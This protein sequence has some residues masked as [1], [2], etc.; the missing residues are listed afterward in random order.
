MNHKVLF[1][2][3]IIQLFA[4]IFGEVTLTIS[5]SE[6]HE[7]QTGKFTPL[8]VT[9]KC[10]DTKVKTTA[11][12]MIF[13]VDVS[14]SMAGDRLTLV[15][16][17]LTYMIKMMNE[18]D[19]VALIKFENNAKLVAG[20]TP[21][22]QANK[23]NFIS[24][25]S[26]FSASGGT[27]IYNGLRMAL[28]QITNNYSTGDRVC[29]IVLLSDG[30]DLYNPTT[31][32]NMFYD[33]TVS[34]GKTKYVFTVH[35]LGYGP[36]HDADLMS[37]ISKVRDGGYAYI[38]DLIT[39]NSVFLQIYGSLST[40]VGS[41]VILKIQSNFKIEK[42]IGMENMYQASLTKAA[43][44]TFTVNLQQMEAGQSY[45]YVALVDISPDTKKDTEVLNATLAAF[46]KTAVY[47]WSDETNPDAYEEY[48]KTIVITIISTG[49][50][51]GALKIVIIND[52]IIW[53]DTSYKGIMDWMY[54]F[55]ELLKEF[56]QNDPSSKASILSKVREL[57]TQKAGTHFTTP[58][59]FTNEKIEESYD[60]DKSGNTTQTL[61]GKGATTTI[62]TDA[63]NNYH[64]FYL[65]SGVGEINDM[66][67]SEQKSAII[68]FNNSPETIKIKS[69]SDN[70]SYYYFASKQTRIQNKIN[71]N[72]G[73][74]FMFRRDLPFDFYTRID[75]NYDIVFNIQFLKLEHGS[76]TAEPNHVFEIKAYILQLNQ[77]AN[78]GSYLTTPM[79]VE[80]FYDQGLR[81]GKISI[82]KEDI[83]KHYVQN[84]ENYLYIVVTKKSPDCNVVYTNVEGQFSFVKVNYISR[85]VPESFYVFN[86][87]N[88]GQKIPHIYALKMEQADGK[89]VRVE[90]ASSGNELD[91]KILRHNTY[92]VS[93]DNLYSDYEKF[94]IKRFNHMGKT[95]ID[96]TQINADKSKHEDLIISI[97]SNNINHVAG[98]QNNKLS[99]TLRFTT[100]S[101]YG[102]YYFNDVNEKN[103]LVTVVR[104]AADAEKISVNFLPIQYKKDDGAYTFEKTRFGVKVYEII[105]TRQ[106][107]YDSIALFEDNLPKMYQEKESTDQNALYFDFKVNTSTNYFLA[108]YTVSS[109]TNEILAY[110]TKKIY[111]VPNNIII[112][113]YN[114]FE[115][116]YNKNIDFYVTVDSSV[117]KNNL[118][119]DVS[120]FENG[121][122][123]S[124]QAVVD[125]TV[126]QST[127]SSSNIILIPRNSC[128]GKKVNIKITLVNNVQAEYYVIVK[129]TDQ[130]YEIEIDEK[131]RLTKTIEKILHEDSEYP[132]AITLENGNVLALS[133]I[134]GVQQM[135]I[136]KL[137]DNAQSIYHNQTIT[138]GYNPD[139][140]LVQPAN[141]NYYVL[142]GH[143][144][145]DLPLRE[146]KEYILTFKDKNNVINSLFRK[147]ALY[148]KTS[149]L[150]LRN[151][152]ILLVGLNYLSGFGAET[153]VDV[154]LFNPKT[155]EILS[156]GQ[157]FIAYSKY[158]SCYEQ[159]DNEVYC[160][161]A[162]FESLFVSK[163]KIRHYTVS[164][165]ALT[166]KGEQSIKTFYTVFNFLKAI[167]YNDEE[168][169]IL[170]QAGNAKD[171]PDVR[172]KG[173]DLYFIQFTTKVDSSSNDI[174]NITRYTYL[175]DDCLYEGQK[176]DAE[177]YNADVAVLSSN[178]IYAICETSQNK[179]KG[180]V[181]YP[182]SDTVHEFYLNNFYAKNV[183]S[184][185]FAKF[186][187]SMGLFYTH[188]YNN[189][190]KFVTYQIMNYPDCHNYQKSPILIPKGFVKEIDF[191]G[192]VFLANPYPPDRKED[193]KVRF[194]SYTNITFTNN[195]N[196][197]NIIPDI[198]YPAALFLKI[199]PRD[200]Y[201]NY[202]IEYTATRK[203][204][205]DG[206]ILGGTCKIEIETPECLE[207]CESCS[208][209]GTNEHNYCLGCKKNGPFYKIND[210]SAKNEG[211]GQPHNCGRCNIS[212]A[213][214]WGAFLDYPDITTNCIKCDYENGFFH[215]EDDERTCISNDTK[216]YW[217]DV[218]GAA[219]YLDS[220]PGP[221]NK[222]SWRWRKCH[223]NCEE[224]LEKGDDIDNKCTF[225]KKDYYFFCN[226]KVGHGIPGSCHTGCKNNGFFVK[227][228]ED[229]EKCCP[230]INHCKECQNSKICDKCYPPY[231]RTD[232]GRLCNETCGYCLAEDRNKW[233]CVNCKEDFDPPRYNLN[234]TCVSEIPFIESL[235]RYHHIVDDTCN[236]L[237]GCK[238][239]CH[240][241]DPWYTDN[242]TM[243]NA[244]Y[245]KEDFY[246]ITPQPKTF[247]CFNKT[248]C[249]GVTKY[250]H[251]LFLRVGGVPILENDINVCLNCKLRNDSY[252]LPEDDF[253]CGEKINRTFNDI[254]DYN[255]L[256]YC[257]KRCLDC[258]TWGNAYVMNCTSCRDPDLYEPR[259]KIGE[260]Y[261]CY[262][263]IHPCGLF[264]YYH[265]YELYKVMGV[266]ENECG[267][268]CDVCLTNFSCPET[269][270]FYH[271]DSHECLEYCPPSDLL[272]NICVLNN[273]AGFF[274]IFDNPFSLRYK[275]DYINS[276]VAIKEILSEQF[277]E[278]VSKLYGVEPSMIKQ[279]IN[280]Y[281]GTG[282]VYNLPESQIIIG[283]NMSIEITSVD[284]ELEKI[285][286]ILAGELTL[287]SSSS[288]LDLS[289]C[290][291]VLKDVYKLPGEEDL[292]I[293]KGDIL[294]QLSELYSG[295]KVQYELF[296]TSM[297]AFLPLK[298][299]KDAGVSSKVM[300]SL[301]SSNLLASSYQYKIAEAIDQD[302]NIF[303]PDSSFY[304]DI[305]T[306]FTNENGNDVLLDERREH[307]F[308]AEFNFCEQGCKY[309]GYN[310][311]IHMYTCNCPI[312]NSNNDDSEYEV[313]PMETPEDFY[314][315]SA[316][317]SNIKVFKC[318]SQVFSAKG[319]KMNFGSYILMTCFLSL[320]GT[321]IYYALKGHEIM[322]NIF[323]KLGTNNK[324]EKYND[325][326]EVTNKEKQ[327]YDELNVKPEIDPN[328]VNIEVVY[329]DEQLNSVD[330]DVAVKE[331]KRTFKE[332]YLSLLKMK[333]LCIFTFYTY[334][335]YN[336][337]VIKFTLFILFISFY[338][339]FTALFFNDSIMREIY[340]YKGNTDAAV[341]IPNII[342]SS[343][344]CLVMNFVI[345]FLSLSEGEI[346]RISQMVQKDIR[347]SSA[348]AL[349]RK[350][351]VK[352]IILFAISGLI[353]GLCWYYVSAF[354][355]VF[356]NSQGHYFTNVLITFI[357]LNIWPC[358]TSLIAPIFR[359]K[360]IRDKNKC[361]YNFSR[362]ISYF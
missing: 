155:S 207:Q 205:L 62:T 231:F 39:V 359:I 2:V 150:A 143:N 220:T 183:K 126:Y 55:Q 78:A 163:F 3:L 235:N 113:D 253:Y 216:K 349:R 245:Y 9:A 164:D 33:Y 350:I 333:Q 132:K 188:I 274:A 120:D 19:R 288:I 117:T 284:L 139:A 240:K 93:S 348:E 81:V 1:F 26:L 214:C 22:T 135:K 315:K 68:I 158:I 298:Y 34:C 125:G 261:N 265:D 217:K 14:G 197:A 154:S 189:D 44:Y 30:I 121:E 75:I 204:R 282:K 191:I 195:Y 325:V 206:K 102:L 238:E 175:Y 95:Y 156:N 271:V 72:N 268:K 111:R 145:Q 334:T 58:N 237:H 180:F 302:V 107:I 161:Y 328:K 98:E 138:Q 321:I 165:T 347:I 79:E 303:D 182:S 119:I 37:K 23:N 71:M 109:V 6:K 32:H 293:L 142:T 185:V 202:S 141:S 192:K 77:I 229:R 27:N 148:Q 344:C 160:I 47:L 329:T 53:L 134:L 136:S 218:Y 339:A 281:L 327:D 252:R 308:N 294:S 10:D 149:T 86:H 319:Q 114:S 173:I 74:K 221:N 89:S 267:E 61:T 277:I 336:F 15:K 51:N 184:P 140:Q 179:F 17:S 20:L 133:S 83:K 295:N 153:S 290:Q 223:K 147:N 13:V 21:M 60:I 76:M 234:K 118:L 8:V 269:L 254:E 249:Q 296:S 361:M 346:S 215:Y 31:V 314:K 127:T 340:T 307:Y 73:G 25:V 230:C 212:C 64:Y 85:T 176:L 112:Y 48:F 278:Y 239:G 283:N 46:N 28:D 341:H 110:Q 337:R 259:V 311:T 84:K 323:I 201:G 116:E 248:T 131:N 280:N 35:A 129:M 225:C 4:L 310:E 232:E 103:G 52:F 362:I 297:G 358:V 332:Y 304:N 194:K 128:R 326:K 209:K 356:K 187:K 42:I 227:V 338:L 213:S 169:L 263:K 54:E 318:A 247:R 196:G 312:K 228:D 342:F 279:Q 56:K 287:N 24:K 159:K 115:N 43:P 256:T 286:K 18:T 291:K 289:E 123:G 7:E 100:Y 313:A 108:I 40:T 70:L 171:I 276:S 144:K 152:Y 351:K 345:R 167:K 208:R 190:R 94:K 270:P 322:K 69:L 104:D 36:D 309:S 320:I 324:L 199:I 137:T 273:T 255:K 186:G 260:Y 87:L 177:Y 250:M 11:V 124:V 244:S 241:C 210:P 146:P 258:E 360:S 317:Y 222:E 251:D 66:H 82:T 49:Y 96:V 285:Q 246:G 59:S 38:Q 352:L 233:E 257:Y 275:Y 105:K 122:L 106:K 355:A 99:Y 172:N 224:C 88:V 211:F 101:N 264:P 243:C 330:Y 41:N 162:Y 92:T 343:L 305:C 57:E 198:D 331:D 16:E 168:G 91:C 306:P 63:A 299:C 178:R 12:D 316:G 226:Q 97:F 353:I 67:F 200:R 219:L 80:A 166:L 45:S 300:N 181:L 301:V 357:I 203:D 335:E 151:G 5:K 29:S 90:F 50:N 236:L 65:E 193:I 262:R 266:P 272:Q 130:N 174:I 292:I 157:S 170:F 242:C 354:C